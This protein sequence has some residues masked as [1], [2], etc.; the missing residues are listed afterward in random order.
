[1][2]NPA[3]ARYMRRFIPLMAA[4]TIIVLG[5]SFWFREGG[6]EGWLRYPVAV[7]PAL[8]IVGVIAAMGAFIAEQKDE[9]QRMVMVRQ[10]LFAIGFTLVVTTIWGF[11]ENYELAPH[12]PAYSTF[13]LF[14]VGL[15]PG[16]A[17][18]NAWKK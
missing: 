8:P 2:K 18:N 6:P 17:L 15:L 5:V 16:A 7:L 4:Y 13:M 12:L 11:L 9:Y 14:C 1:M 3:A 10:C